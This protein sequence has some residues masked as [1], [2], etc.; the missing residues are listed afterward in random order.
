LFYSYITFA[1]CSYFA[2]PVK[3]NYQLMSK[4][5]EMAHKTDHCC[6]AVVMRR[7]LLLF[8]SQTQVGKAMTG[9]LRGW[10]SDD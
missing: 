6:A 8:L 10:Q 5:F 2:K 4:L 7:R 1:G 3:V 9:L